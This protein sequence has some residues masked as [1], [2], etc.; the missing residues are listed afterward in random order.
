MS[1][2]ILRIANSLI[3]IS[4]LISLAGC[5]KKPAEVKGA[6]P[7]SVTESDSAAIDKLARFAESKGNHWKVQRVAD[8]GNYCATL[9]DATLHDFPLDVQC[10][11][12]ISR[13]VESLITHWHKDKFETIAQSV[14][15]P[16]PKP[17]PACTD[18]NRGC[19]WCLEKNQREAPEQPDTPHVV[20][21]GPI[22]FSDGSIGFTME[23]L[24]K[25][26]TCHLGNGNTMGPVGA[27]P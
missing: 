27:Q 24:P 17:W 19:D 23:C 6:Q 13:A 18:A 7:I 14:A 12:T 9:L 4:F 16:A 1:Q 22:T 2:A 21:C 11:Q 8:D 5:A 3:L 26:A 25:G 10:S 15:P 20:Y